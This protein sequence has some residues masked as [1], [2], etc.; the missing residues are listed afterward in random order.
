MAATE[1][2]PPVLSVSAEMAVMV[3]PEVGRPAEEFSSVRLRLLKPS[4]AKF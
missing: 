4:L 3:V 1:E 2:Q